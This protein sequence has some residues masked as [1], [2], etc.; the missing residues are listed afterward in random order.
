MCWLIC[1]YQGSATNQWLHSSTTLTPMEWPHQKVSED[2]GAT[3]AVLLSLKAAVLWKLQ[4]SV[5]QRGGVVPQEKLL[6]F[7]LTASNKV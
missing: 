7:N 1:I 6:A 3:K 4:R 2:S 5:V